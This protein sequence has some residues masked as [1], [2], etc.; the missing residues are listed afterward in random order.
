MENNI[1]EIESYS[2]TLNKEDVERL[3]NNAKYPLIRNVIIIAIIVL[4]LAICGLSD[5][6]FLPMLGFLIAFL[7]IFS[8]V[9]IKAFLNLKKGK[10]ESLEKVPQCFYSYKVY[11]NYITVEIF[12]NGELTRFQQ[13]NFSDIKLIRESNEFIELYVQN[14]TFILKRELLPSYSAIYGFMYANPSKVKQLKC[15]DKWTISSLILFLLSFVVFFVG[16]IVADFMTGD[17]FGLHKNFWVLFLFTPVPI[18]SIILGF[19]LKKKGYKYKKNIIAGFILLG[20]MCLY[21][22]FAFIFPDN[23]D[24]FEAYGY[25]SLQTS[26]SQENAFEIA[27]QLIHSDIN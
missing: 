24:R 10:A 19:V 2:F 16:F 7:S 6:M 15:Y 8:V 4:Y 3:Y 14:Q 1:S 12:R 20:L 17:S 26:A 23:S 21:G 25:S 9:Y 18:S 5:G 13:I 27:K 22:S 11:E